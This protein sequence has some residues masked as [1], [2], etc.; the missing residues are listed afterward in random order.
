MHVKTRLLYSSNTID[1][2]DEGGNVGLLVEHLDAEH[3]QK[4]GTPDTPQRS[5]FCVRYLQTQDD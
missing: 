5:V 2:V 3:G 4:E 1:K